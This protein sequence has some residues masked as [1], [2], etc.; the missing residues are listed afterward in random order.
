MKTKYTLHIAPTDSN[1]NAGAM[2]DAD[3]R[4]PTIVLLIALVLLA[5]AAPLLVTLPQTLD[6]VASPPPAVVRIPATE[7]PFHEQY[8]VQATTSWEDTLDMGER[9]IW[10]MRSSD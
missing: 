4:R 2:R 5:V 3:G 7:E 1:A 6:A 10:R 8:P 9:A